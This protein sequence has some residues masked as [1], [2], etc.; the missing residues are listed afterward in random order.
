MAKAMVRA[1]TLGDAL[2]R[3]RYRR[4]L[5][6]R[7]AAAELGVSQPVFSKWE[8]DTNEPGGIYLPD[9]TAWLGK[10]EAKVGE[11]LYWS[12]IARAERELMAAEL[13]ARPRRGRRRS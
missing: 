5:S 8:N 4:E 1:E 2:R 13:K 12:K 11:L 9:I 3:E 10:S 7:E 6:Q